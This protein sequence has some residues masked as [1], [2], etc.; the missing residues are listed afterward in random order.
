[1]DSVSK[2][3][4]H[5]S[6][7]VA[8]FVGWFCCLFLSG[9]LPGFATLYQLGL[10]MAFLHMGILLPYAL[11]CWRSYSRRWAYLPL[12]R[13]SLRDLLLPALALFVLMLIHGHFA[14]PETW[15]NELFRKSVG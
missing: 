14:R 2:R 5:S 15:M 11:F 4:T 10:A 3:L 6:F 7:C 12:G 9:L 8:V 13:F 1:M